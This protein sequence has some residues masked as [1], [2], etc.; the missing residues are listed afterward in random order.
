MTGV[1][2]EAPV[3]QA[4]V[5]VCSGLVVLTHWEVL[6]AGPPGLEVVEELVRARLTAGRHGWSLRL[7]RVSPELA[8]L[9]ELA[10]LSDVLGG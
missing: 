5:T 2:G 7:S 4:E 3:C 6:T 10:G 1:G 8:E 9:L